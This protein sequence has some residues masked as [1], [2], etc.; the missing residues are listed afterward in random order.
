MDIDIDDSTEDE[1]GL[2][3]TFIYDRDESE[4]IKDRIQNEIDDLQTTVT[5]TISLNKKCTSFD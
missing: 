4:K 5:E 3:N 1:N 2:S